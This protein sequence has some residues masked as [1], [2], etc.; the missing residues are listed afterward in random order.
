MRLSGPPGGYEW[1]VFLGCSG[2]G[3]WFIQD[4]LSGFCAS[5][6]FD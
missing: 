5:V 1:G 6:G 2:L 3:L 4:A